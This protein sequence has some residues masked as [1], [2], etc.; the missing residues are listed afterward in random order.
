MHTVIAYCKYICIMYLLLKE[1][2]MTFYVMIATMIIIVMA[3]MYTTSG[4][5]SKQADEQQQTES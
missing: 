2:E 5:I 1:P 3:E 4:L